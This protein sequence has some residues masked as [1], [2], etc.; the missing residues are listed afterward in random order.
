[1]GIIGDY[2]VVLREQAT[3]RAYASGIFLFDVLDRLLQRR[4]ERDRVTTHVLGQLKFRN[5]DTGFV[6]DDESIARVN[7]TVSLLL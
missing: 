5:Q 3:M 6:Y 4:D 2:A 7:G 1:M